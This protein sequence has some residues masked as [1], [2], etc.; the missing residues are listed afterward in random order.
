MNDKMTAAEETLAS[1]T[2]PGQV[3]SGH[4]PRVIGHFWA[5]VD[6]RGPDECWLWNGPVNKDG[7]GVVARMHVPRFAYTV[8]VGP[9]PDGFEIKPTCHCRVCCNPNH[10]KAGPP[11]AN[12]HSS[13]EEFERRFWSNIDKNGPGGCWLWKKCVGHFG[14]GVVARENGEE[15][16][17]HRIAWT[18]VNGPIPPGLCC[19]HKCDVPACC[20]PDHMFLGTRLDNN[21]DMDQ[22]GRS[23]RLYGERHSRAKLTELKVIEAR[24][25]YKAGESLKSM[26]PGYGVAKRVLWQ[27][28]AGRTW[29]RIPLD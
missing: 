24:S 20:R 19:L 18:L 26:A 5:R 14:Y 8:Q 4:S 23:N 1:H 28:V 7:S 17:A 3:G 6:R 15:R 22:K 29:K 13:Q 21:R 9:I 12:R 27:A 11:G 16:Q 2:A 10:L 25:R